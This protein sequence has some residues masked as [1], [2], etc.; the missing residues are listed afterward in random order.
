M[1]NDLSE[2]LLHRALQNPNIGHRLFWLLRSEMNDPSV[3]IKFG[4]L[5]EA[6]ELFMNIFDAIHGISLDTIL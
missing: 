5:L 2:F 3:S 1:H 6:C 4:L